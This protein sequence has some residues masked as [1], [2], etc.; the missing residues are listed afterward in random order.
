[1]D[2]IKFKWTREP[3]SY[4]IKDGRIEIITKKINPS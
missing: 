2:F 3:K 4:E 1:M